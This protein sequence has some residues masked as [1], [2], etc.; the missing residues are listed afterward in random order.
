MTER[1][2]AI[3]SRE[4]G[5]LLVLTNP[6]RAAVIPVAD[7]QAYATANAISY[8][9]AFG[10]YAGAASMMVVQN[11]FA[12]VPED[13]PAIYQAIG[14]KV[15]QGTTISDADFCFISEIDSG[16]FSQRRNRYAPATAAVDSLL[17]PATP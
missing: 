7:I 6:F 9:A 13:L 2:Y 5:I 14:W 16:V 12:S 8:E 15:A 3:G 17:G 10:T 1:F 11:D 4:S